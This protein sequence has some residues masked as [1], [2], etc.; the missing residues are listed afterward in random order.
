[1]SAE[2]EGDMHQG[3][4]VEVEDMEGAGDIEEEVNGNVFGCSLDS[5]SSLILPLALCR[6][7]PWS[8]NAVIF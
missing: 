2:D 6:K 7:Y 3:L 5:V 1:M 4:A 8:N